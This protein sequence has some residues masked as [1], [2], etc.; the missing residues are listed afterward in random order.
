MTRDRI[1]VAT[2]FGRMHAAGDEM[3]ALNFARCVDRS[4]FEHL[5]VVCLQ[6][7]AE[8]AR[9][10]VPPVESYRAEG[11][12]VLELGY[13]LD[14]STDLIHLGRVRSSL[15]KIFR[16]R[17]VD[18][19]DAR[20]RL[21]T[22]VGG[23]AARAAGVPVIVSTGYYPEEWPSVLAPIG[24]AALRRCDAFVT[25]AKATADRYARW[26]GDRHP[27]LLVIPNGLSPAVPARPRYEVLATLGL[28]DS[29]P[30]VTQ[31][32]RFLP[33]KS[34]ETLISAAPA[35]L[36]AFPDAQFLCCGRIEDHAYVGRLR[37]LAASLGVSR[38]VTISSYAGA[39]GD[40]LSVSDVFTHLS[41]EDSSPIAIH[42]AMSVG[43][44]I[45]VSDLP[46]NRE[47]LTEGQNAVIVPPNN[48][49]ATGQ[50]LLEL[51]RSPAERERL[52]AAARREYV[53]HHTP[54]RMT[55]A[56]EDLFANLL[57]EKVRSENRHAK[58]PRVD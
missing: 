46:G 23:S 43:L 53:D 52:G 32:S 19:L 16:D 54:E 15:E 44:P 12:E 25:D 28:P 47:L 13:T 51:L 22:A 24:R 38:H 55:R 37:E 7:S 42:E 4:R 27:P 49:S 21:P 31:V 8:E 18:V 5:V 1:V 56:I 41:T 14:T 10:I 48:P 33:R 17:R 34:F 2:V 6:L 3:R 39:V 45:V 11:V 35:V 36:E 58:V 57:N 30:I 9:T 26:L 40:V 20:M 29:G 50:A